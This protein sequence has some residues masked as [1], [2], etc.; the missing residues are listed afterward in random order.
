MSEVFP[1]DLL[2]CCHF[3][4]CLSLN[5]LILSLRSGLNDVTNSVNPF[6]RS[7]GIT[8]SYSST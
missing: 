8:G 6:N 4:V 5:A 2:Y 7:D 1:P 3:G